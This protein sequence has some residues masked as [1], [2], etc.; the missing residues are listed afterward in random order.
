MPLWLVSVVLPDRIQWG[1]S[2]ES[3][4]ASLVAFNLSFGQFLVVV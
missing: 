4:G 1:G 2:I 3:A